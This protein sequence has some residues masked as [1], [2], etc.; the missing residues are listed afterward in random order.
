MK[1]FSKEIIEIDG[2][3][4]TLFLNRLGVVAFE[5]YTEKM[6]KNVQDMVEDVKKL[7]E[8]GSGKDT[9]ITADTNPF[10]DDFMK[11]SEELL[12]KAEE[13]ALETIQRMYWILLYTEH[14]LSLEEVKELYNKACKE[15]GDEQV[16]ALA[17]QMLE[18]VQTNKF[19]NEN[20]DLKN[21]KAL[22]QPK[23]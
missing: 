3:E 16:D 15:Y 2:K 9:E 8:E 20:K 23:K 14:K 17:M 4:Y 10:E 1:E 22:H 21:L 18:E 6:K 11:K 7:A 19:E 12:V 5:K 13:N